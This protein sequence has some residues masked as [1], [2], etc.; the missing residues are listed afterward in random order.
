M[1]ARA[2]GNRTAAVSASKAMVQMLNQLP[3]IDPMRDFENAFMAAVAPHL[4]NGKGSIPR[5]KID[6][7]QPTNEIPF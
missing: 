1:E 6:L 2:D 3:K 7:N 4:D 5:E